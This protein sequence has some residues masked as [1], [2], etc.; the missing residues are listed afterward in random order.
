VDDDNI[1]KDSNYPSSHYHSNAAIQKITT[2]ILNR[3]LMTNLP[4]PRER[5][6]LLYSSSKGTAEL[7]NVDTDTF[8]KV[9]TNW[10]N[11]W[12]IIIPGKFI[13][14]SQQAVFLYSTETGNSNPSISELDY[15]DSNNNLSA[16]SR[17][18]WTNLHGPT[19]SPG[20]WD[21]IV[22]GNFGPTD[23]K[24]L[25]VY[26]NEGLLLYDRNTS[27]PAGQGGIAA[28]WNTD[29]NGN[30][31]FFRWYIDWRRTWDIIVPGKFGPSGFTGLLCY[32]KT[33]GNG[34]FLDTDGMGDITNLGPILDGHPFDQPWDLIIQG[35]FS[36]SGFTGLFFTKDQLVHINIMILM[37]LVVSAHIPPY[38]I[39]DHYGI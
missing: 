2:N 32:D 21:I 29:G 16:L 37:G 3:L 15:M 24:G 20:T 4:T 22:R 10:G 35:K 19:P 28:F 26:T 7:Y 14:R 36:S 13:N 11:N 12:N 6:L 18:E 38:L 5:G 33:K 31:Q 34:Q 23:S 30:F 17:Y 1:D 8:V 25:P 9:S 27:G 39:G